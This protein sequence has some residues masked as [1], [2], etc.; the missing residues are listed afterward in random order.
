[1]VITKP[2]FNLEYTLHII[3]NVRLAGLDVKNPQKFITDY[4]KSIKHVTNNKEQRVTA[5]NTLHKYFSYNKNNSCC[6]THKQHLTICTHLSSYNYKHSMCITLI[7]TKS[8]NVLL[9]NCLII[10]NSIII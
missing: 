5:V 8:I 9:L 1:M 3:K 4:D 2:S 6:I 10:F 7:Y